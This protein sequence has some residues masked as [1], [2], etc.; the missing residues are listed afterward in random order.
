MKILFLTA[1]IIAY[2]SANTLTSVPSI[3]LGNWT[4]DFALGNCSMY[5]PCVDTVNFST[6]ENATINMNI[7]GSCNASYVMQNIVANQAFS[8][9]STS[10]NMTPV[11][12]SSNYWT[13]TLFNIDGLA[14]AIEP[15]YPDCAITFTKNASIMKTMVVAVIAAAAILLF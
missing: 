5:D 4:Y 13:A 12:N 11:A 7:V 3:L 8:S 1:L 2:A 10:F 14:L 9:N 6:G 15:V